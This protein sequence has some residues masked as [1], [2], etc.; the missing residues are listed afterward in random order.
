[1]SLTEVDQVYCCNKIGLNECNFLWFI[2]EYNS[3]D[4]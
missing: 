1:M 3:V 4:T 2:L